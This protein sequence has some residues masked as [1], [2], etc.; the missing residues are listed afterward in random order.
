[1]AYNLVKLVGVFVLA[2]LTLILLAFDYMARHGM[3][4]MGIIAT[5]TAKQDAN[6][7]RTWPDWRTADPTMPM[8]HVKGEGRDDA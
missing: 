8:E 1:M 4:G 6:T 7:R 2:A 3:S 5:I